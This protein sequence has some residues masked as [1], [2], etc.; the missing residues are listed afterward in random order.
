MGGW[1]GFEIL[2]PEFNPTRYQKIFCNL[3]QPTKS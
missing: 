3:T 1:V 2:W